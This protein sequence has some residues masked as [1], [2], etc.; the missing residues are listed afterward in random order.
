M[1]LTRRPSNLA[2]TPRQLLMVVAGVAAALFGILRV[3]P[4]ARRP[5]DLVTNPS[6]SDVP[7]PPQVER[8]VDSIW[9]Q[10]D[11]SGDGVLQ[12]AEWQTMRGDPARIDADRNEVLSKLEMAA[13]ILRYAS[14][15][16]LGPPS[17]DATIRARSAPLAPPNDQPTVESAQTPPA[18]PQKPYYV[19]ANALP[20]GL[21]DWFSSGDANGDGQLSM[22]EYAP[23]AEAL[24]V[25]E[26]ER[27]DSNSDGL[28]T[29]RE[30][31][32]AKA[33]QPAVQESP[34]VQ[35]PTK[36]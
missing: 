11:A 20:D 24:R 15:R 31:L 8:Y 3:A 34:D 4:A 27:L 35:Q 29:P 18:S 14:G 5:L 25:A 33:T 32:R 23:T 16:R 28:L 17:A 19:P 21:P 1:P 36:E 13:H 30:L 9:Q 10:Y 7:P 12:P 2:L 26:F 6:A 22:S